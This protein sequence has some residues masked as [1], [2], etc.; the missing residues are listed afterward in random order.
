MKNGM[1]ILS[2]ALALLAVPVQAQVIVNWGAQILYGLG[3]SDGTELP[4]GD[5]IRIGTFLGLS[6]ADI[7]LHQSDVNALNQSFVEFGRALIGDGT[8]DVDHPSGVAA[9]W[10]ASPRGSTVNL[11]LNGP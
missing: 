3:T 10:A 1:L 4:V 5:L 11:A 8:V 7:L 6:D 2:V 9:H